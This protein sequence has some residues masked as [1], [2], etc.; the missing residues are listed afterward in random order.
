MPL[1]EIPISL[2]GC[3]LNLVISGES[4]LDQR[5]VV[6]LE[7]LFEGRR[8]Y[9]FRG[10][11]HVVR[12]RHI[13][14]TLEG[15]EDSPLLVGHPPER[16]GVRCSHRGLNRLPHLIVEV[17]ELPLLRGLHDTGHRHQL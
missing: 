10:V 12:G 6:P 3:Y 11:V 13:F 1:P 5:R 2:P 8:D 7:G 16:H 9:E 15:E 17:G 4:P 14:A